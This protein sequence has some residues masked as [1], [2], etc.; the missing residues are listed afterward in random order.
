MVD[1]GLKI[2][3]H[4]Q[5]NNLFEQSPANSKLQE[6]IM[7]DPRPFKYP[8]FKNLWMYIPVMKKEYKGSH[9]SIPDYLCPICRQDGY[10]IYDHDF[11]TYL[12]ADCYY[13]MYWYPEIIF[14]EV[15]KGTG[16]NRKMLYRFI[17][18]LGRIRREKKF[19][20]LEYLEV[21]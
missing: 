17:L 10:F 1:F 2:W 14:K 6:V 15:P 12:C 11:F 8:N 21:E 19:G 7:R 5:L 20:H 3:Y 13:G 9:V 18:Q 4:E 16:L